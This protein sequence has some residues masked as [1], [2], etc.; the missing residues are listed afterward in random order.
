MQRV[1]GCWKVGDLG[2]A[3]G[4]ASVHF[5]PVAAHLKAGHRSRFPKWC[6][7]ITV[8]QVSR[9]A[10][11]GAEQVMVVSLVAQLITEFPVFQQHPADLIG[12]YQQAQPAIYGC[13]SYTGE[14]DTQ[15]L[16]GERTCLSGDGTNH[17]PARF[18][19]PVP[20]LPQAGNDVIDHRGRTRQ[21]MF[22]ANMFQVIGRHLIPHI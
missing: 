19:V 12:F 20:P 1:C 18:G 6:L 2:G 3:G 22:V 14:R 11:N 13:P 10:A 4:A 7:N 8:G 15:F 21:R 5:Q 16:S 17:Q 9:S